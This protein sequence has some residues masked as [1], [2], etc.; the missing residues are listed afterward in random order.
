VGLKAGQ[1]I[2]NDG[3][4]V[5]AAQAHLIGNDGASLIGNDGA[6]LITNDGA[7]LISNDGGGI[8]AQG[9]GNVIAPAGIISQDGGGL[10]SNDG[11]GLIGN[12]GGSLIGNDG[13]GLVPKARHL[14]E[15]AA[16]DQVPAAGM[17]L[18]VR[19][20]DTHQKV[21]LGQGQDGKPVYVVYTNL[22]GE[23]E[24]YLPKDLTQNVE[25][26]A[27]VPGK[28]DPRMHLAG[29]TPPAVANTAVDDGTS[30]VI[31]YIRFGFR[32]FA[33]TILAG[34]DKQVLDAAKLGFLPGTREAAA[35]AIKELTDAV[36]A[37]GL[38]KVAAAD[39][40]RRDR[41]ADRITDIVLAHAHLDQAQPDLNEIP[42]QYQSATPPSIAPWEYSG[43]NLVGYFHPTATSALGVLT[44]LMATHRQLLKPVFADPT[45]D[46]R[47]S[48]L[49][50]VK[51]TSKRDGHAY[52]FLRPSDYDGF[53]AQA[54]VGAH[55]ADLTAISGDLTSLDQQS[56]LPI[57]AGGGQWFRAAFDGILTNLG[58][59][60][61]AD[62]DVHEALLKLFKDGAS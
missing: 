26:V 49:D 14:L 29:I 1:L 41:I 4:S 15:A 17:A 18:Y 53:V 43:L 51:A 7:S 9:A 52:H 33:R 16:V 47:L 19:S 48:G 32:N 25:V 23:Y 35:P 62:T 54:I 28:P 59:A 60:V 40:E 55:Q 50:I 24:V 37:A 56:Q 11:G 21:S 39:P 5:L 36:K 20:L 10:I 2:G 45:T 13:A 22:K 3:A 46:Q 61:F 38:D 42:P 58:I 31:T 6:S 8:V 57:R 27:F 34:D 30:T 12:D 44:E